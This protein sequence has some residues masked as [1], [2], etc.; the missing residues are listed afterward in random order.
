VGTTGA[1][2]G[3]SCLDHPCLDNP[4]SNQRRKHRKRA[5]AWLSGPKA[6]NQTPKESISSFAFKV[7]SFLIFLYKFFVVY[8]IQLSQNN[9]NI[10]L[11]K[12]ITI[13]INTN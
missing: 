9:Y 5:N 6:A 1:G 11:K 10:T 7:V 12:I 8:E 13:I 4:C 2:T 3:A